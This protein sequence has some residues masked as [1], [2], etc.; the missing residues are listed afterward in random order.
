[1]TAIATFGAISLDTDNPGALAQFYR[2]LLDLKPIYES[3]DAVVLQNEH[4]MLSIERVEEHIRP[5]WPAN[6]IPKQMHLDLFVTDLD[7]AEHAAI[8]CGATKP[9]HQ[10]AP[11]NWRVLLDPAGHPFC[12]TLPPAGL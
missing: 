8:A 7:T 2:A 4:L 9:S 11:D 10:P 5:D 6:Q 3:T 1:M 12:L